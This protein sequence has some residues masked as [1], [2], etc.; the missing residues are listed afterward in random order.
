MVK[1]NKIILFSM[2]FSLFWSIFLIFV[3]LSSFCGKSTN[4]NLLPNKNLFSDF[5]FLIWWIEIWAIYNRLRMKIRWPL[6]ISPLD[7]SENY[8]VLISRPLLVVQISISQMVNFPSFSPHFFV[9][10]IFAKISIFCH[11]FAWFSNYV[12]QN[13]DFFIDSNQ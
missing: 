2:F 7:L 9:H 3:W 4:K 13:Y 1:N 10:S 12:N 6:K 11:N 8:L 5:F